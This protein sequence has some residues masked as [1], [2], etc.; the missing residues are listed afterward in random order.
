MAG[1]YENAA[2]I[3]VEAGVRY[4]EDAKVNGELDEDG[5][6]IPC[7]VGSTWCPIIHLASGKV[8]GWPDGTTAYV[9]YKVCDAGRY[10]LLDEDSN[11]LA[12]LNGYVPSDFLCH[13]DNGYGDYI[14]MSIGADG[15]IANYRRPRAAGDQ[16][17]PL[18]A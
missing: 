5:T 4:W 12:H 15:Q 1:Q 10:W 6:L 11:P 14:I 7:R 3:K 18:A 8:M 9:H 17:E 16:W 2:Y 13:G